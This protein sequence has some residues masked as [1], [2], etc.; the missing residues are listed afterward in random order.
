MAYTTNAAT[1][2]TPR[3]STIPRTTLPD[4]C[5]YTLGFDIKIEPATQTNTQSYPIGIVYREA[6]FPRPTPPLPPV[7]YRSARANR[8]SAVYQ[9]TNVVVWAD[10]ATKDI[11]VTLITTDAKN[12]IIEKSM[13]TPITPDSKK[14]W[15]RVTLVVADSFVEVYMNGSLKSTLNTPNT[16]KQINA[17]DFYPPVVGPEVGGITIANM[18]MWPRILTSKEIRTYE[19][20]PMST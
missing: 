2:S 15:S 1:P 17:T 16:L 12:L 6:L 4:I 9:N 13:D 8:L 3:N 20:A 11:Q 7:N 18:S 5:N 14:P 19:G 10:G